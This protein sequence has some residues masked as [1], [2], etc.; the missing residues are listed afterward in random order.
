MKKDNIIS[1]RTILYTKNYQIGEF[2]KKDVSPEDIIN[3]IR[4]GRRE[5]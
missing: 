5:E 2:D 3:L 1:S 4:V